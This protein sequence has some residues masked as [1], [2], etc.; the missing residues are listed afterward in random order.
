MVLTVLTKTWFLSVVLQEQA[1]LSS[2][3]W[4]HELVFHVIYQTRE[5]LFHVVIHA[6]YISSLELPLRGMFF[7]K[8]SSSF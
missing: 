4:L 1:P 6:L 7:W 5:T 2:L 8:L 3:R